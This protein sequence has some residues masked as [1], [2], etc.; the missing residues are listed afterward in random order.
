MTQ[1][2]QSPFSGCFPFASQHEASKAEDFFDDEVNEVVFAHPI[3]QI[4][5]KKHGSVTSDSDERGCHVSVK[6]IEP[7]WSGDFSPTESWQKFA[8]VVGRLGKPLRGLA[9]GGRRF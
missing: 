6:Q 2:D 9:K 3:P 7:Q 4:G 1:A 8:F 5:R